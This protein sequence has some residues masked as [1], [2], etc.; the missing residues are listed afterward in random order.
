MHINTISFPHACM[1]STKTTCPPRLR[2]SDGLCSHKLAS[3]V[4]VS[5]NGKEWGLGLPITFC[6]NR[7]RTIHVVVMACVRLCMACIRV[8][9]TAPKPSLLFRHNKAKPFP[10]Q[11]DK[12]HYTNY[13]HSGGEQQWWAMRTPACCWQGKGAW[14]VCYILR[15]HAGSDLSGSTTLSSSTI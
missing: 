1:V 2:R 9:A 4:P 8:V 10:I 15:T 13:T 12:V 6:A 5:L 7:A 11:L 3:T 14:L